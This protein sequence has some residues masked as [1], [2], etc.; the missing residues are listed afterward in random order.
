[1]AAVCGRRQPIWVAVFGR[2][3]GAAKVFNAAHGGKG[4]SEGIECGTRAHIGPR[5][6]TASPADGIGYIPYWRDPSFCCENG[7]ARSFQSLLF[8]LQ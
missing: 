3:L 1:M 2:R 5:S 7:F 4:P 8:L 6:R